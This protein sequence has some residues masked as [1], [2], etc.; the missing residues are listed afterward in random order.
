M[1]VETPYELQMNTVT[2]HA[3]KPNP[4]K[5]KLACHLCKKPG[6]YPAQCHQLKGGKDQTEGTKVGD[7]NNNTNQTNSSPNNNKIASN[8]NANNRNNRIGRKLGF[9][10]TP[11]ET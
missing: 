2:Q 6:H 9:V 1:G 10:H 5:P 7:V 4:A 3:R 11:C 8:S